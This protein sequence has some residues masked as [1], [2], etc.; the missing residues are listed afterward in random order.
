ML[1]T[2]TGA[3]PSN[4]PY[5]AFTS[6]TCSAGFTL[7][8]ICVRQDIFA[9]LGLPLELH[10]GKIRRLHIS[11]DWT[12]SSGLRP[13]IEVSGV[14][15]V[16]RVTAPN[17]PSPAASSPGPVAT[18]AQNPSSSVLRGL[19]RR[20]CAILTDIEIILIDN[21]S[22]SCRP[23]SAGLCIRSISTEDT[24][25]SGRFPATASPAAAGTPCSNLSIECS[26]AFFVPAVL[27]EEPSWVKPGWQGLPQPSTPGISPE[28]ITSIEAAQDWLI[29]HPFSVLVREIFRA[30]LSDLFF[31]LDLILIASP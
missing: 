22:S 17:G 5:Y 9:S 24:A 7:D 14:R 3:V 20:L 13:R 29:V 6:S 11:G 4:L 25:V 18:A 1:R 15:I 12:Y 19:L 10:E 16:A 31:V 2:S 26:G 30:R 8:D 21:L 23:A 27:P 28:A